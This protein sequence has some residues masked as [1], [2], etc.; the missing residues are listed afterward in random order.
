MT[1]VGVM[2]PHLMLP[3]P[4]RSPAAILII[5]MIPRSHIRFTNTIC[6]SRENQM[7]LNRF[8]NDSE[9]I[10]RGPSSAMGLDFPTS[11]SHFMMMVT[12]KV[13]TGGVR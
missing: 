6:S 8:R 4:S 1:A 3:C 7:F 11:F 5:R 13:M 9:I 10:Q 12:G 2:R